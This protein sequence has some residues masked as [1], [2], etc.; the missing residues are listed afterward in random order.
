MAIQYGNSVWRSQTRF[1]DLTQF[2]YDNCQDSQSKWVKGDS[3]VPSKLWCEL[4]R[5][6]KLRRTLNAYAETPIPRSY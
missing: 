1:I 6:V 2:P 5:L 3:E 4:R